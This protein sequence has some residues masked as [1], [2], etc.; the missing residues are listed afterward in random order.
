VAATLPAAAQM[1]HVPVPLPAYKFTPPPGSTLFPSGAVTGDLN[2]DGNVDLALTNFEGDPSLVIYLADNSGALHA[3]AEYDAADVGLGNP[4]GIVAADFDGDGKLDLAA[5]TNQGSVDEV[6]VLK[7]NGTGGFVW[8]LGMSLGGVNAPLHL[9]TRDVNGDGKLDLVV[10]AWDSSILSG[11]TLEFV[12]LLGFGT[13]IFSV[14]EEYDSEQFTGTSGDSWTMLDVNNDGRLDILVVAGYYQGYYG[15]GIVALTGNADGSFDGPYQLR[16]GTQLAAD[17]V[18]A[19][20]YFHAATA[21]DIDG[22]G[23][24][25]FVFADSS[26]VYW[27]R[28]LGNPTVGDSSLGTPQLIGTYPTV[29]PTYIRANDFDKNGRN[30]VAVAGKVFL[31]QPNGTWL[32]QSVSYAGADMLAV[33]DL[34]K[35]GL[36]DLVTTGSDANHI[37][38]VKNLDP[39]LVDDFESGGLASWL[40]GK[41]P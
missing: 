6:R 25:D 34:D 9:L 41:K 38:F 5:T 18:G 37:A 32:A 22:D 10:A 1:F 11:A 31:R 14:P 21:A 2:G 36:A 3:S 29:D 20:L 7:G 8:S 19:D 33:R 40:G 35:D 4:R 12:V 23:T 30:D 13:G 39:L 15:D 27:C 17:F 24:L 26:A 28:V 16:S